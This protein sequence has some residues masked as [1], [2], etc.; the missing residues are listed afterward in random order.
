M[1]CFCELFYHLSVKNLQEIVRCQ[2]T[3]PPPSFAKATDGKPPGLLFVDFFAC[4]NKRSKT[5]RAKDALHSSQSDGWHYGIEQ[6]KNHVLHL[7]FTQSV[8]SRSTLYRQQP[9]RSR[10]TD[11]AYIEREFILQLWCKNQ[12]F[13]ITMHPLSDN[14]QLRRLRLLLQSNVLFSC[15]IY[16]E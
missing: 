16:F 3:L 2:V 6:K 8:S 9:C 15:R 5:K 7:H 13:L 14:K 1:Y 12:F 11:R 4:K 10:K